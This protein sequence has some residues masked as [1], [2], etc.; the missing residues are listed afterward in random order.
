M[1]DV[2]QKIGDHPFVS[3][4]IN[5]PMRCGKS[6][7]LSSLAAHLSTQIGGRTADWV[8][9]LRTNMFEY[10]EWRCGIEDSVTKGVTIWKNPP[11][12]REA[13]GSQFGLI[14][15]DAQGEFDPGQDETQSGIIFAFTT[16]LTSTSIYNLLYN[17]LNRHSAEPFRVF[18]RNMKAIAA[19]ICPTMTFQRFI[20][21]VRDVPDGVYPPGLYSGTVQPPN[22]STNFFNTVF[23]PMVGAMGDCRE[24]MEA[25]F[26]DISVFAMPDPG[27]DLKSDSLRTIEP[28]FVAKMTEF[29]RIL[30]RGGDI[31]FKTNPQ[32][33][34]ITGNEFIPVFEEFARAIN[35]IEIPRLEVL[36]NSYLR[37]GI[38]SKFHTLIK[39]FRASISALI[40]TNENGMPN[41]AFEGMICRR[42]REIQKEFETFGTS[43]NQALVAEYRPQ[44]EDELAATVTQLRRMNRAKIEAN[45]IRMVLE[46][47]TEL[48]AQIEEV[49]AARRTLIGVSYTAYIKRWVMHVGRD[50]DEAEFQTADYNNAV[51]PMKVRIVE[52]K[53][54]F[55]E[56]V[57]EFDRCIGD[58]KRH[59]ALKELLD[60]ARTEFTAF[61]LGT[62]YC[63]QQFVR[64]G[65]IKV[66]IEEYR[67]TLCESCVVFDNVRYSRDTDVALKNLRDVEKTFRLA[68]ALNE[69]D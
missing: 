41:A 30:T 17:A 53:G 8:A 59:S 64:H 22:A 38:L 56:A 20:L 34:V 3:N 28:L 16:I 9:E 55:R 48:D 65:N 62:Y 69:D 1:I 68:V 45:V 29:M 51:S 36:F 11:M 21:L 5:G 44:F 39:E 4:C 61:D 52:Q 50:I 35:A 46:Q 57:A 7:L 12:L 26:A 6:F 25:I 10:F 33:D 43:T 49:A 2:L 23:R 24:E 63:T 47:G 19:Q 32:G 31:V 54:R 40:D 13:D 15:L 67:S 14:L 27:R 66:W 58:Y 37:S 18:L 42:I 60:K